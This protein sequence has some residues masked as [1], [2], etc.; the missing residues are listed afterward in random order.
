MKK[1]RRKRLL[2]GKERK[3]KMLHINSSHSNFDSQSRGT[4]HQSKYQ[5]NIVTDEENADDTVAHSSS[6]K[7]KKGK[8]GASGKKKA[9]IN[10]PSHQSEIPMK[11]PKISREQQL[12][13]GASQNNLRSNEDLMNEVAASDNEGVGFQITI[14]HAK[15]IF[16]QH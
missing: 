7:K 2:T 13:G 14:N 1:I 11:R 9:Y 15:G 6:K 5:R 16:G 10:D 3:P 12:L 4:A 8:K